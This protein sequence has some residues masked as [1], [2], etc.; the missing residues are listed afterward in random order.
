MIRDRL[1]ALQDPEYKA[2]HSKLIPTVDPD[3]II[4]VRV[5]AL[6]KLARS[7]TRAEQDFILSSL[8]HYY[9][10]ESCIHGFLIEQIRDY[11]Q[12]VAELERFLP[13]VDNWATC[14]MMS[15]KVL[16]TAPERLLT[17]TQ[18]WLSSADTYTVRFGI[19]CMMRWFL[20]EHFCPEFPDLV[21]DIRTQEYY[22]KM[23]IAWYMAEALTKQYDAACA[24]LRSHKLDPWTHNKAIQKARESLRIS[25]AQK[26]YLK[27]L[28]R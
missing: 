6:R 15:P 13:H 7:L 24:C 11:D 25:P 20:D 23:A 19:L 18:K 8:P 3:C 5:P 17:Q 21:A 14:D 26:A 10:E 4:G 27:T 1:F 28:K 22:V 12:C 16:G 2:F 9:Y